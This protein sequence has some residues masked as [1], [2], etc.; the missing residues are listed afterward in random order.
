ME[1]LVKVLISVACT[2]EYC[3]DFALTDDQELKSLHNLFEGEAKQLIWIYFQHQCL[4][5]TTRD[6]NGSISG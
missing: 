4:A 6:D 5:L 1:N 2:I 3:S